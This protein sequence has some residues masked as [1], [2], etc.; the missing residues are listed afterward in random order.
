MKDAGFPEIKT[1]GALMRFAITL[2]EYCESTYA[3][4]AETGGPDAMKQALNELE[5][6]HQNVGGARRLLPL[7]GE[8]W[9][10]H[11]IGGNL[12][13]RQDSA[14]DCIFRQDFGERRKVYTFLCLKEKHAKRKARLEEALRLKLNEVTIEPVSSLNRDEYLVEIGDI[15]RK[16]MD[17]AKGLMRKLEEK[18]QKFYT[19]SAAYSEPIAREVM[20]LFQRMA[21]ENG[22]Y[23]SKL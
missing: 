7:F 16:S 10:P 6:I 15:T 19:D 23:L 12:C 5:K 4:V 22:K 14:E 2:E 1:F 17:E 18:S 9:V 20:R 3:R 8:L 11:I 21:K 13:F